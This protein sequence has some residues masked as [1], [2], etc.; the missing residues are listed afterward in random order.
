MRVSRKMRDLRELVSAH[1]FPVSQANGVHLYQRAGF[2]LHVQAS[3]SHVA[4]LAMVEG[5]NSFVRF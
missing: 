4:C 1:G 5:C 2:S 3:L